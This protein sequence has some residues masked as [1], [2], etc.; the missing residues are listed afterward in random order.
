MRTNVDVEV[1]D[2]RCKLKLKLIN[3]QENKRSMVHGNGSG[4][5]RLNRNSYNIQD[6][7]TRNEKS[8]E[9]YQQCYVKQLLPH[10]CIPIP[11]TRKV[12]LPNIEVGQ[13]LDALEAARKNLSRLVGHIVAVQAQ[14]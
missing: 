7:R 9:T 6:T 2:L 1:E 10:Q 11:E 3:Y 4:K 13:C 12:A 8:V 5:L 14:Q